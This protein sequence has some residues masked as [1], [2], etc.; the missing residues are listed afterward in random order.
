M[1]T[2]RDVN[3]AEFISYLPYVIRLL[4]NLVGLVNNNCFEYAVSKAAYSLYVIFRYKLTE[5]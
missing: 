2:L 3:N 5:A 1:A 4:I